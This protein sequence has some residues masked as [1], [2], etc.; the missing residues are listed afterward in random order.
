MYFN[1][2]VEIPK[3]KGKIITKKKGCTTYIL[4]QYGSKYNAEKRYAVP[5][6]TIV[7]KVSP[8]DPSLMVPNEK[9]QIYFPDTEL[10]TE[11]PFTYRSCVL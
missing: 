7:G 3:I 11:L 5:L 4:Y 1:T 8:D 10:P 2:T 9:F 6:R